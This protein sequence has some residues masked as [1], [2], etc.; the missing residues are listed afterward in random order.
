M[1][2]PPRQGLRSP[3]P[4]PPVSLAKGALLRG[5]PGTPLPLGAERVQP[6]GRT[7]APLPHRR[8]PAPAAA[9]PSPPSPPRSWRREDELMSSRLTGRR[10][11]GANCGVTSE[12]L[13]HYSC[14]FGG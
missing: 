12:R 3:A 5:R 9:G 1:R 10:L 8:C 13:I 6:R 4:S 7:P 11:Y 2:L 14:H